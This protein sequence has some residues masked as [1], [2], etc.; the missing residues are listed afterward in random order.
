MKKICAVLLALLLALSTVGMLPAGAYSLYQNS[1]T[2][3]CGE[4]EYAYWEGD[5]V[6]ITAYTGSDADV[7]IPA[8]LD[9]YPVASIA[10][11]AFYGN[12]TLVTVTIPDSV[13]N[14]EENPFAECMQL[15]EIKMSLEQPV[16]AVIDGVLFQKEEKKLICYPAGKTEEAYAVPQGIRLIGVSAFSCCAALKDVT[17]P[18]GIEEIEDHAFYQCASL[19]AMNLPAGLKK[20]GR[21]AF[22]GC[23]SLASVNFPAGLEII[24]DSTFSG[25]SA[26]ESVTLL[27]GLTTIEGSAFSNCS[28]L[29]TVTLPDGLTSLGNWTFHFCKA[30]SSINLPE[31]LTVLEE[32]VFG[33]CSSLREISLPASL[34]AI[35]GNPFFSIPKQLLFTVPRDS[36]AAAGCKENERNYTYPDLYDWLQN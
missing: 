27:E 22:Y 35:K 4:Y 14:I 5:T 13:I 23:E 19:T 11:D 32:N 29:V 10:Y 17:L 34:T 30:L 3:T 18:E 24:E 20:I 26:L 28:S 21:M 6:E 33:A 7:I 25:C 16:F 2:Y 12:E 31:G 1:R 8:Q 9:E 15:T 36:Y